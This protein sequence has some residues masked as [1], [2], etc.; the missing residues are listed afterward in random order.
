MQKAFTKS[1][2]RSGIEFNFRI[3]P[4]KLESG[5]I[6]Y[7]WT[8]LNPYD[9]GSLEVDTSWTKEELEIDLQASARFQEKKI[10]S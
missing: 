7:S 10:Q 4:T 8:L 5:S 2:T 6:V 1:I 3:I 9:E